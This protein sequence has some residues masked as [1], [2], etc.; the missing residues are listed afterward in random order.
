MGLTD[1]QLAFFD[2]FGYLAFPG[3]FAD[4]IDRITG[5]FENVWADHGGGHFGREHDGK[6]RSALIQFIDQDEYLSALIDD[7]RIH[8]VCAAVLGDDFNY[9]GSDGNFYVGDTLWHSDGYRETKYLSFKMAFY[10][11]PVTAS[12]GCLRVIPGSHKYGDV[13]GNSLEAVREMREKSDN[14]SS[15]LWGVNGDEVPAVPLEATPGDLVMFNHQIKHSSWGGGD[16]RRMFTLNFEERYAAEDIET[17]K[18]RM[19]TETRFWIER[20]Y[21]DVMVETAD[22]QRM[23]HLEQRMANDGHMAELARKAREEMAEPSRG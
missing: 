19:A 6:Q 17:L 1:H 15:H 12:T 11:D 4:D 10:L 21:G 9:A 16:R 22:E 8:D 7:P 20:N 5:A 13:F 14:P 23:V 3:L 18:E 2:T